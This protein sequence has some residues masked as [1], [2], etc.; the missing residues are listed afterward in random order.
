[1]PESAALSTTLTAL[2]PPPPD[3]R[4]DRLEF[5]SA[6]AVTLMTN[7]VSDVDAINKLLG[8]GV[9]VLLTPAA[10]P[11]ARHLSAVPFP[12]GA[13]RAPARAGAPDVVQVGQLEIDLGRH[14]VSWRGSPLDL[15]EREIA[16]LT[17]LGREAGRACSFAGLFQHAWGTSSHIDPLAI[18]SAVQRLR[19]KFA[20][21]GVP[22]GIESVRGYGFRIASAPEGRRPGLTPSG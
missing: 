11:A 22:V 4:L 7:Y 15:S 19:R 18:H 21:A 16:I 9:L 2:Q 5:T 13:H 8:E 12:A 1:M 14:T 3:Q 6:A 17:C 20:A 10:S